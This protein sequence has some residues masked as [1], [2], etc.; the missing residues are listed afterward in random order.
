MS[1]QPVRG[2]TGGF[3]GSVWRKK[4]AGALSVVAGSDVSST[5][6]FQNGREVL[7]V[8]NVQLDL[9]ARRVRGPLGTK[10]LA[11]IELKLLTTLMENAGKVVP[12]ETLIAVGWGGILPHS[13]SLDVHIG[14]L[15]RK[16]EPKP[17]GPVFIRS[18]KGL[19]YIFDRS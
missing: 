7:R 14:R 8:R 6:A 15:R 13:N 18:V 11:P 17:S 1:E 3:G 16:L 4:G 2:Q 5:L 9:M 19:G 12:S 10:A